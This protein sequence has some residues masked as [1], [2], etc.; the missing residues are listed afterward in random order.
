MFGIQ[1]TESSLSP[2]LCIKFNEYTHCI[3]E[4]VSSLPLTSVKE[5]ILGNVFY[6]FM[7]WL[8]MKFMKKRERYDPKK[9]MIIYNFT[10]VCLATYC[11]VGMLR[12]YFLRGGTL[13]CST[14]SFESESDKQ[15]IWVFYIFYIQKY[16]EFLDTFIFILRK[17]YRQVTFLHVYHHSSITWM[18]RLFLH[19]YPGGSNC[20]P[21]ILNSFVHMLMYTH[22]LCS[23][24]GF[25]CWW[26]S[27]LTKLQLI[28]FIIITVVNVLDVVKYIFLYFLLFIGVH[29][30]SVVG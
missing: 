27:Y 29:A 8:L 16:W 23:C 18:V 21:V 14:V 15:L 24:L 20:V 2:E 9:F 3:D 1:I 26:R 11:F 10:C 17:S 22:Y 30:R 28:Q 19:Y 5:M 4:Y 13:Y 7:I 6:F 12:Y 25:K